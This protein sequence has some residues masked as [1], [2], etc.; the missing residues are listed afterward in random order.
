MTLKERCLFTLM[1]PV[2]LSLGLVIALCQLT[3]KLPWTMYRG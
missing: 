3:G 2:I 1:L